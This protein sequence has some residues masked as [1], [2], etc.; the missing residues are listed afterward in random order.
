MPA[1]IEEHPFPDPLSN[2]KFRQFTNKNSQD[3]TQIGDTEGLNGKFRPMKF[4]K[5]KRGLSG[6]INKSRVSAIADTG[7]AQNVISA[8]YASDLEL[9]IQHESSSFQ[10]GN[11]KTV[12]SISRRIAEPVYDH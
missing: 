4:P 8:A 7:S 6:F 5:S 10:L 3:G 9:P 11:S 2:F 1:E 12:L